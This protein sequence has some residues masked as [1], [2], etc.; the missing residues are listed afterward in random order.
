MTATKYLLIPIKLWNSFYFLTFILC[1]TQKY[2]IDYST[3]KISH[4]YTIY[5]PPPAPASDDDVGVAIQSAKI[6]LQ[7][8]KC[9]ITFVTL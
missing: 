4:L 9:E 2:Y 1:N 8:S 6:S 7:P 3:Y 5:P